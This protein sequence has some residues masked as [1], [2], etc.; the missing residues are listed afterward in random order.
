MD[1]ERQPLDRLESKQSI[2]NAQISAYGS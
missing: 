2:I 1:L